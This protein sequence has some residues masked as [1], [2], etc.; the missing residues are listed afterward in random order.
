MIVVF[1]STWI[2][3]SE[4]LS[5]T[6]ANVA[7]AS[8]NSRSTRLR[9]VRSRG[10]LRKTDQCGAFISQGGCYYIRPELRPILAQTAQPSSSKPACLRGHLKLALRRF[11]LHRLRCIKHGDVLADDL[12]GLVPRNALGTG[13]PAS[14]STPACPATRWRSP[15]PT[16]QSTV[17]DGPLP[18]RSMP[19]SLHTSL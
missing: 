10:Q 7:L 9:S 12:C 17:A 14:D 18:A 13:I 8:A 11:P 1:R 3:L 19:G 4:V 15:S 6:D 16:R 5:S 2:T